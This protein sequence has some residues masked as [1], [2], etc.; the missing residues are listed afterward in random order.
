MIDLWYLQN[1]EVHRKTAKEKKQKYR[2]RF[3]KKIDECFAKIPEMR[4]SDQCLMPEN[5]EILLEH[6][7]QMI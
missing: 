3:L 6:Q 7:C 2:H 4:P 5:K 1:K